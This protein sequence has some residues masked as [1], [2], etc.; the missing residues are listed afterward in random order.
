MRNLL[1]SYCGLA[2]RT[3]RVIAGKSTRV[4]RNA[5]ARTFWVVEKSYGFTQYCTSVFLGFFHGKIFEFLSV[6]GGFILTFN[7]TYKYNFKLN[8]FINYLLEAA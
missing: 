2:V 8:R 1:S 3:M 4:I 5:F 6:K 7:N